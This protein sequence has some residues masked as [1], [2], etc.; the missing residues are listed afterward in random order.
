MNTSE[1]NIKVYL[2][3]DNVPETI[4][5]E[6]NQGKEGVKK[7]C[8]SFLLSVWDS[9]DHNTYKI[10]L[11]TKKMLVDDMN[12]HFFQTLMTMSETYLKA[13]NEK[14]VSD[15]LKD[16]AYTFGEKTKVIKEKEE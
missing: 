5:W 7:K 10:D 16:M 12:I 13:T 9:N 3:E 1:I 14:E 6:S 2:G 15:L 4:E 8:D 11:W